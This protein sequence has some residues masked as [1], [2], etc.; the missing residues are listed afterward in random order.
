M[1]V[2]EQVCQRARRPRK[3]TDTLEL[4]E[5]QLI[6]ASRFCFYSR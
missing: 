1:E 6:N 5:D 3:E 4:P 2:A